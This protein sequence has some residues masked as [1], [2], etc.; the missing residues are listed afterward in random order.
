MKLIYSSSSLLTDHIN[1][2][3]WHLDCHS[4]GTNV[5]DHRRTP[6]SVGL[7]CMD[8]CQSVTNLMAKNE[9]SLRVVLRR[10]RKRLELEVRLLDVNR[11]PAMIAVHHKPNGKDGI[12]TDS[13]DDHRQRFR[14]SLQSHQSQQKCSSDRWPDKDLSSGSKAR[15]PNSITTAVIDRRLTD[16]HR[17]HHR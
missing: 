2:M 5:K 17:T 10:D 8:K 1:A 12:A 4:F 11:W 15:A 3:V 13:N 14:R 9:L 16:T 7:C 6:L